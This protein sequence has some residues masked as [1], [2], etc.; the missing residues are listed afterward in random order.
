MRKGLKQFLRKSLCSVLCTAMLFSGISVPELPVN[1][2][3]SVQ[4]QETEQSPKTDTTQ[5]TESTEE[6]NSSAETMSAAGTE[7]DGVEESTQETKESTTESEEEVTSSESRESEVDT[8]ESTQENVQTEEEETATEEIRPGADSR[9]TAEAVFYLYV[10]DLEVEEGDKIA[11][12]FWKSGNGRMLGTSG[13]SDPAGDWCFWDAGDAYPMTK[14]S[15]RDGWYS[16]SVTYDDS[17]GSSSGFD[18]YTQAQDASTGTKK[19]IYTNV[20]AIYEKLSAGEDC[21]YKSGTQY[22]SIAEAEGEEQPSEH[23]KEYNNVTVNLNYY[24]GD[25]DANAAE[26]IGFYK[27]GSGITID[28]SKNPKLTWGGWDNAATNPVYKMEKVEGH[29]GWFHITYT[30]NETIVT[31]SNDPKK[32]TSTS[33]FG[34]FSSKDK[35]TQLIDCSGYDEKYPEIYKGLLEGTVIAIKNTKGVP[36]GYASIEEAEEA[37]KEEEQPDEPDQPTE[38][39][40]E[41]LEELI[42][43][44]DGYEEGSYTKASWN[45]FA[46]ALADAKKI[47]ESAT[48]EEIMAAYEALGIAKNV[49]VDGSLSVA[50]VALANDFITGADLSSYLSL[51]NT[52]LTGFCKITALRRTFSGKKSK[53]RLVCKTTPSARANRCRAINRIQEL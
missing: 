28:E 41:Q 6:N 16:I 36:V 18:V 4:V 32:N 25:L 35:N 21:A 29:S 31:N 42:T 2:A 50:K 26:E 44:A 37:T 49:L 5:E 47:T 48:K 3:E 1:A 10:G 17:K 20:E 15:G 27:W 8:A 30:A 13:K 22:S 45:T 7:T 34:I 39:T 9:T 11:V 46:K 53:H 51:K 33:G 24:V 14:V 43:E 40:F 23:T 38:W 19:Q 12:N 52:A